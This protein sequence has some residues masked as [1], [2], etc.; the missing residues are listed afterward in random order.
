M[1]A[2]YDDAIVAEHLVEATV[3]NPIRTGGAPFVAVFSWVNAATAQNFMAIAMAAY[4]T[5][6]GVVTGVNAMRASY[7]RKQQQQRREADKLAFQDSLERQRLYFE[8]VLKLKKLEEKEMADSLTHQIEMLREQNER[9]L[10]RISDL[11]RQNEERLIDLKHLR[12]T[13]HTII[14][15]IQTHKFQNT[16]IS[17]QLEESKSELGRV[18]GELLAA[19]RDLAHMTGQLEKISPSAQVVI[20]PTVPEKDG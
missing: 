4:T 15:E 11:S 17:D 8:E 18:N 20:A 16:L 5:I 14:N 3:D 6:W 2:T 1:L 19:R 10:E 7:L 13:N 12:A 9:H